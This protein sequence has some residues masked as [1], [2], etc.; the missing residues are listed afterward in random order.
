MIEIVNWFLCLRSSLLGSAARF[1]SPG[2]F[3]PFCYAWGLFFLFF[4]GV[5]LSTKQG[6]TLFFLLSDFS[7]IQFISLLLFERFSFRTS[8]RLFSSLCFFV[9]L[10]PRY[11]EASKKK[12]I[13]VVRSSESI[14]PLATTFYPLP[15]DIHSMLLCCRIQCF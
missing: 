11:Q 3:L 5:T 12:M 13:R 8:C 10:P 9:H 6:K 2:L 4:R 1:Y 14:I 7:Y 15:P